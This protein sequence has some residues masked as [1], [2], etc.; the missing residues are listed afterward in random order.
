MLQK[1]IILG[2]KN[3]ND[4][5][6]GTRYDTTKLLIQLPQPSVRSE[7]RNTAGHDALDVVFGTSLNFNKHK[8]GEAEYPHVA[9]LDMSMTTKGFEIHSYKFINK[10]P[11]VQF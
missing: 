6:E 1:F 4:L 5:V 11:A 7:V 9:E 10:S 3:F 8:L 2:A